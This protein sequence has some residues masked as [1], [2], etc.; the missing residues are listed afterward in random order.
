MTDPNLPPPER[1][2]DRP[3][4]VHHTTVNVAPERSSGGGGGAGLIIGALVVIALIVAAV[5]FLN[6]APTKD[7]GD[8]N[9]DVDIDV[10][11][12]SLPELPDAPKMPDLPEVPS[13]APAE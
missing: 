3:A 6:N 4:E 7:G 11:A 1:P 10:P 13:P 9:L 8:T 2:V 5:L 12:P